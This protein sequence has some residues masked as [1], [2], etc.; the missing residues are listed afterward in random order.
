ML[1]N[2]SPDDAGFYPDRIELIK[3]KAQ[4]WLDDGPAQSLVL[5]AARNGVIALHEAYGIARYDRTDPLRTDAVFPVASMSKPVTATAIMMLVEAG[6]L[7]LNRP[8]KEYFP[9]LSGKYSERILV[10]QLLTHTSGHVDEFGV[11][12]PEPDAAL[13]EGQHPWV[14]GFLEWFY[15]RDA[16]KKPGEQNIYCTANFTLLGELVRRVSGQR[17]DIYAREHIFEPL[18]MGSSA[19][20]ADP[21]LDERFVSRDPD[22]MGPPQQEGEGMMQMMDAPDGGVGLRTTSGD[23]ATFAEL[24]RNGGEY[25]GVRLLNE[26]TV[27]EMT[28][29]QIPGIGTVNWGRVWINEASWGLGWMIQGDARWRSS[30]GILQ[31]RGTFYHQGGTGCAF[32][33][34]PVHDVVGIYLSS[35][36]LD[37]ETGDA[38]WEFDKFQNMVTAAVDHR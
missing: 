25:G 36:P 19:F 24:Y 13:P 4:Q 37:F 30:H 9:E 16:V 14:H 18:G 34:D 27:A 3:G 15:P 5:L 6:D 29:N 32:W 38:H 1:S 21:R 31:P 33:I 8:L 7:S 10:H 20:G 26:W 22:F 17:L 28:R 11:V 12:L 2:G 23:L 35:T